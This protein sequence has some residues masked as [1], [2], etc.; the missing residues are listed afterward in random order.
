MATARSCRR[1][2]A[3]HRDVNRTQNDKTL[4]GRL[5]FDSLDPNDAE[6]IGALLRVAMLELAQPESWHDVEVE[7]TY[8]FRTP[9]TKLPSGPGWYVI[10]DASHTPLYVGESA[11]L[12]LRLNSRNGSR[13][14]FAHPKR[15]T[16]A[17]RNFS[18][19]LAS[20][21]MLQGLRVGIVN[22]AA[23]LKELALGGS[24][25]KR[26]AVILGI[27]RVGI[28]TAPADIVL[29]TTRFG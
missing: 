14:Q 1:C 16:D 15:A 22:E 10:V 21:G 24:L 3:A 17:T 13:D 23:V 19:R 25:S 5:V 18:K 20:A 29:A 26:I 4:N 27:F 6:V 2:A 12:N 11:N 28:L 7:S 9:S 8:Y